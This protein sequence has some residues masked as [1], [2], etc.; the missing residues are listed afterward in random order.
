[1]I[2]QE[3]VR[4]AARSD[5]C[6]EVTRFRAHL[7]H[8]R[9]LTDSRRAL[10]AE[11]RLPAAGDEPRDQHHRL[12]GRRHPCVGADHQ[13]QGRTRADAGAGP[14][15]RVARWSD[16]PLG[17]SSSSCP[18]RRAPARPRWWNGS[19][20]ACRTC[21]CRGLIRPGPPGRVS[22][23]GSTIISSA[24]NGSKRWSASGEFLEWADVFGNYYGTCAADTEAM[25]ARGEDVVLVIDVQ[26][27]R[28]VRRAG[29]RPSAS[30]CCPHRPRFS[31]SGC[32][33]AARTAK[34]RFGDGSRWRARGRRVFA[35]RVR[36]R[37]RRDRGGGGPLAVNRAGRA[38]AR[39]A[40]AAEDAEV[41]HR[42]VSFMKTT[43]KEN[44][45]EFVVIASKRARQ[46][47]RAPCRARP[48][49]RR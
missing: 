23:T 1:M 26:G 2:A 5:I 39:E 3:I 36:R 37:Q 6:E 32:A 11:A 38:G 48:A 19:C 30:S 18:P 21:E 20:S 45:F 41:H 24:A 8:W 33:A 27:A 15:C 14:E 28:Q 13:R 49:R 16:A 17:D 43:P 47:L 9:A 4:A 31:S 25:L 7:A 22:R 35:V 46:L 40:R 34:S 10:R 44:R 12:K 29:S 42:N